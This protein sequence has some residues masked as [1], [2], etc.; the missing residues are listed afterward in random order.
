M[1]FLGQDRQPIASGFAIA[2]IRFAAAIAT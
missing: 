2:L 1:A